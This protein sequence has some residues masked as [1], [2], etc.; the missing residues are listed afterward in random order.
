MYNDCVFFGTSHQN[1]N[2]LIGTTILFLMELL[3][4]ADAAPAM[5]A[6]RSRPC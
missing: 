1:N 4:A 6:D 2:L 3:L 5:T